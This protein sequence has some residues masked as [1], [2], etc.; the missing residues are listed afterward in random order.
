MKK[1]KISGRS[2]LVIDQDCVLE[3]VEL[4]GHL[5][6]KEGGNIK[7]QHAKK[8]YKEFTELEGNEDPYLKIRGYKLKAE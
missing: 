3:E 6:L 7:V 2:S 8:D 5:H 4:D 1:V